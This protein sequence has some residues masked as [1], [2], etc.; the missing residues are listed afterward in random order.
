MTEEAE[1]HVA[2]TV[3]R[4][5]LSNLVCDGDQPRGD[6]GLV[7]RITKDTDKRKLCCW[8]VKNCN[9]SRAKARGDRKSGRTNKGTDGQMDVFHN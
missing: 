9:I 4:Q 5:T 7:A 2:R 3:R 6:I 1:T 8:L